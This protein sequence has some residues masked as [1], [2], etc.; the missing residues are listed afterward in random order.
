MVHCNLGAW[1]R[2]ALAGEEGTRGLLWAGDNDV[3]PPAPGPCEQTTTPRSHF[4][5]YHHSGGE[6]LTCPDPC[7]LCILFLTC[8]R[9]PCSR[10]DVENTHCGHFSL[11]PDLGKEEWMKSR[12]CRSLFLSSSRAI[13]PKLSWSSSL[14]RSRLP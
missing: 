2:D 12:S 8:P 6:F 14:L 11:D 9:A 1:F 13:L 3:L 5:W 7:G 10:G 4:T